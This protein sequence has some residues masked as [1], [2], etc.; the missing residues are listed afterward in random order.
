M[1]VRQKSG[2]E[3]LRSLPWHAGSRLTPSIVR[4]VGT[5]APAISNTVVKISEPMIGTSLTVPGS[6]FPGQRIIPG[7]RIPP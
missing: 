3:R 6:I 2:T 1:C 7:T 4:S 5:G